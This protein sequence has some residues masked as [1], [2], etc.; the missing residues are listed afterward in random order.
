[1]LPPH[2]YPESA[3]TQVTNNLHTVKSKRCFQS[4]SYLTSQWHLTLLTAS[5]NKDTFFCQLPF[6]V[7]LLHLW[8]LLIGFLW[9][10]IFLKLAFKRWTCS[11]LPYLLSL[12]SLT[13]ASH[14]CPWYVSHIYISTQMTE[15][16]LKFNT[17]NT[18][19]MIFSPRSG[20]LPVFPLSVNGTPNYPFTQFRNLAVILG[21]PFPSY[22]IHH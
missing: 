13:R 4:S 10:L 17:F 18:K 1:M 8:G 12:Y 16:Q 14:L 20:S 19:P 22:P 6:F 9:E 2:H 3:F 7:F 21:N 15:T 11:K 5:S